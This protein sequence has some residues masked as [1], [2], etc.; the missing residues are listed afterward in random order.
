M[1]LKI[2]LQLIIKIYHSD[3]MW[4][5]EYTS[6]V[7]HERIDLCYPEGYQKHMCDI[8]AV[9]KLSFG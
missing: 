1:F 6:Q 7:S 2:V 9:G 5:S 4:D 3:R 8:H